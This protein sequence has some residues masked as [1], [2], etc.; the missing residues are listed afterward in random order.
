LGYIGN[1]AGPRKSEVVARL[2]AEYFGISEFQLAAE[3][4]DYT[5]EERR[6]VID[7]VYLD[8]LCRPYII[9]FAPS[10]MTQKCELELLGYEIRGKIK[11]IVNNQETEVEL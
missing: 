1:L 4:E 3:I 11:A 2:G 6:G 5:D 9:F 7:P 10:G 8:E